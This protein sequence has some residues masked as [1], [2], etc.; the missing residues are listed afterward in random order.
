MKVAFKRARL[1]AG[2]TMLGITYWA[3]SYPINPNSRAALELI[4]VR[5]V[6]EWS[7]K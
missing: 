4:L 2:V 7:K 6:F 3:P 5:I 1:G